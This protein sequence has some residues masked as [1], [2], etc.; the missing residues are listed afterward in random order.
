MANVGKWN[1]PSAITTVLSTEM[2][3]LLGMTVP[4]AIYDNSVNLDMYCDIEVFL[5]AI[6][7]NVSR[8]GSSTI[9]ILQAVDGTNFPAPSDSDLRLTDAQIL[10]TIPAVLTTTSDQ[11]YVVR[12]VML[13]PAKIKFQFDNQESLVL[14]G[15]GNTVKVITYDAQGNG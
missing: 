8:Q 5:P 6:A 2:D 3:G 10:C 13:P 7:S 1:T 9:F 15:S 11:R 12:N 4:S 14:A